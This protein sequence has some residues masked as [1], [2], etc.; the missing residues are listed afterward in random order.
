MSLD[1]GGTPPA[2][3]EASSDRS[4]PAGFDR[5]GVGLGLA[6][7]AVLLA[8]LLWAATGGTATAA[9]H[10]RLFGGSLVLDGTASVTVLEPATAQITVQLPDIFQSVDASS[11]GQ[12]QAVPTRAGTYL[13]NRATGTFNLLQPDNYVAD[14][15]GGG[16]TLGRVPGAS[17]AVGLADGDDAYILRYAP[18]ASVGLIDPATVQQ[19]TPATAGGT[20]AS[21]SGR[22]P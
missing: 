13:V 10:P 22:S 8:G 1:T 4:G 2:F 14:P 20:P 11:Y 21:R 17:G 12:V 7:V 19:A 18:H 9:R 16:V 6:L 5:L 15:T 3:G